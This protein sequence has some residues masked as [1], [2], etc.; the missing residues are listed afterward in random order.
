MNEPSPEEPTHRRRRW[1]RTDKI[2]AFAIVI[3]A[4]ITLGIWLADRQGRSV[5]PSGTITNIADELKVREEALFVE[6]KAG[7]IPVGSEVWLVIRAGLERR[8]YPV[9]MTRPG[10]DGSWRS[11]DDASDPQN[12]RLVTNGPYYIQIYCANMSAI[13]E[14]QQYKAKAIKSNKYPGMDK[15]PRGAKLLDE[16]RVHRNGWAKSTQ[17]HSPPLQ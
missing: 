9:M 1:A 16:K 13:A 12:V 3:S 6:G 14:F 15:L 4:V 10:P 2:A 5:P 11:D 8:W 17:G 7:D